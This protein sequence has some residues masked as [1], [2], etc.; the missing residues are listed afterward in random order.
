LI[1]FEFAAPGHILMDAA[2]WWMGFPTCWCAG[3]I[4]D[5]IAQ[6]I[7]QAYRKVL[8][9]A[10]PIAADDN[11]FAVES[12]IIR[13]AWLFDSLTWLLEKALQSEGPWGTSTNRN[14]ILHYLQ[15]AIKAADAAGIRRSATTW[16]DQLR[17]QWPNASPLGLYPAFDTRLRNPGRP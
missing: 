8:A 12:A 6:R 11:A 9:E 7:D 2:Y 10:A 17:A 14:R 5:A 4:P 3:S 13:I 15:A 1:D 16:M